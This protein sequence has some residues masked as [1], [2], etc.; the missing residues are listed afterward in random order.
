MSIEKADSRP[1]SAFRPTPRWFGWGMVAILLMGFAFR[2]WNLGTQSLWHDEAWSIFSAYHPLAWGAQGT[3][4]NA[5]ALF[6]LSL[7]AW[8]QIAGDGVWMLRFWSL[9][10]GVL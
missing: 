4:P 7:G 10:W 6:Y 1:R 9:L 3:D 8:M 5:P 2:L